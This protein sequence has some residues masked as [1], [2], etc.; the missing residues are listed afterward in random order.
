V[1]LVANIV[2]VC[3]NHLF[4]S[5]PSLLITPHTSTAAAV[6]NNMTLTQCN[7]IVVAVGRVTDRRDD[8]LIQQHI[9]RLIALV[10]LGT[11]YLVATPL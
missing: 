6:V 3:T 10:V 11:K 1:V 8:C 2:A 5:F 7:A 9:S 4:H